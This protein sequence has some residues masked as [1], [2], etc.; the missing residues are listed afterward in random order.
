MKYLLGIDFGGGASK[1]TLLSEE[2]QIIAENT[3]EYPTYHPT[4]NACEQAPN[5]WL[6]AL[7]ENTTAV[8]KK[9]GI[10]AS[11]IAAIAIDSAT[12]PSL[13]CDEN[14]AP[15]TTRAF[16][17]SVIKG[18]DAGLTDKDGNN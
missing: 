3:V 14:F 2:G 12:H 17:P 18:D 9:S 15:L 7:C 8:L 16:W 5:D 1:V 10:D 13:V 11:H 4:D 6:N